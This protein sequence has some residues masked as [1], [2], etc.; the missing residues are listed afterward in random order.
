MICYFYEMAK[1]NN[2]LGETIRSMR[3]QYGWTQTDLAQK[4][5]C[6]QEMIAYYE[7]GER[8]PPADKIPM[9]ANILGV[10]IDE[11]Y[12]AK[13]VKLN[14]RNKDPRLWKRFEQVEKLPSAERRT[15]LKM[16]DGLIA[17]KQE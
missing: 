7:K 2:M 6:S 4:L 5:D 11:L 13:P 1:T 12:G 16:I 10:S 3:K 17:Q 14:G 8:K 15:I 9:L